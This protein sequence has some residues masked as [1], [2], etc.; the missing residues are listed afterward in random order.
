[1]NRIVLRFSLGVLAAFMTVIAMWSGLVYWR[2][3]VST[4]ESWLPPTG[5]LLFPM[6]EAGAASAARRESGSID[7]FVHYLEKLLEQPVALR[8]IDDP[9]IFEAHR[10]LLREG[11]PAIR[12]DQGG[13]NTYYAPIAGEDRAIAIGPIKARKPLPP[14]Q[15]FGFL[16][17]TILVVA[18]T[19][20]ILALPLMRMMN[21]MEKTALRIIG[22]D[23]SARITYRRFINKDFD[24]LVDCFNRMAEHNQQLI[25]KQ[26]HLFQAIVHEMRTPTARM[27][28]GLEML[29]MATTEEQKEDRLQ[30]LDEDL[31]ELDGFVEELVAYNR[32]DYS[33]DLKST[34][35]PLTPVLEDERE[36]LQ[37]LIGEREVDLMGSGT[38]ALQAD[39][40]LFAR[41]IRNLI[42]NAIRYAKTRVVT[43]CEVQ[44]SYVVIHVDD[45][46]P[47][48]PEKDRIRIFEP[49]M[50]LEESRS[51]SSGG[52]GLG[53]AIVR[54][55]ALI[56]G[57]TINVSDSPLGGAR[58]TLTWPRAEDVP[59]KALKSTARQTEA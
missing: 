43:S 41:A 30:V 58:F 54:R 51:K 39:A 36:A 8:P 53:L 12:V 15:L 5:Q 9:D 57:A 16:I 6:L 48:V 18:A 40:R 45:D 34:A 28:F 37:H 1:M 47:G 2:A 27:R 13:A 46:G 10:K 17:S 11:K 56:H 44:G 7:H 19:G 24:K 49:F 35:V 52:V 32:L 21:S 31:N 26:Q 59:A 3:N 23:L 25:E 22:G 38:L 33:S 20:V 50:R 42:A 29:A 55:I 4:K 14:L